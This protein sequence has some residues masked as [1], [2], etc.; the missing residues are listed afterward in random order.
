MKIIPNGIRQSYDAKLKLTVINCDK[1][2]SSNI[3]RKFSSV[4]VNVQRWKELKQKMIN[5]NSTRKSFND[6]SKG[7]F[8]NQNR[9]LLSM[10]A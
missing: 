2:N 6:P 1:K 9:K 8:N 7:I 3:A 5:V 4:E 10:S